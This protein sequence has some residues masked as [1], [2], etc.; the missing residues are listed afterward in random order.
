MIRVR[1]GVSNRRNGWLPRFLPWVC[2]AR[3]QPYAIEAIAN[4]K[5]PA[6]NPTGLFADFGSTWVDMTHDLDSLAH[7]ANNAIDEVDVTG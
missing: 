1:R 3:P 5:S 4:R 7:R 6:P 2:F